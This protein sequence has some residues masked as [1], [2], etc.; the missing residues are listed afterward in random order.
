MNNEDLLNEEIEIEKLERDSMNRNL[1]HNKVSNRVKNL[2]LK[3]IE[4]NFICLSPQ[5]TYSQEFDLTTLYLVG[6]I[7]NFTALEKIFPNSTKVFNKYVLPK[8]YLNPN[9]PTFKQK[10]KDIYYDYKFPKKYNG[11]WLYSGKIKG[12]KTNLSIMK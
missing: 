7:F 6:G 3:D 4:N 1:Y 5:G 11:Y 9:K 8:E 12:G 10:H 2:I